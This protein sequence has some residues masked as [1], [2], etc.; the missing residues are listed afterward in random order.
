MQLGFG[1]NAKKSQEDSFTQKTIMNSL[2]KKFAPEFLNR[3]DEVIIFNSLSE[4]NIHSIIEIK[5][6][7]LSISS[8]FERF[9]VKVKKINKLSMKD[10]EK[11]IKKITFVKSFLSVNCNTRSLIIIFHVWKIY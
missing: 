6:E 7:T 9:P 2:K 1:T 8:K 5:L 11:S 10:N 4:Q 3:I